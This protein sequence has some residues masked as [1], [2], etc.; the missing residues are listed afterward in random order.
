MFTLGQKVYRAQ[1]HSDKI[2]IGTITEIYWCDLNN[3][4]HIIPKENGEYVCYCASF[5]NGPDYFSKQTYPWR[6]F[7]N[8]RDAYK[9][10]ANQAS[11][12]IR[13]LQRELD[14]WVSIVAEATVKSK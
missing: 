11:R 1:F 2:E 12:H 3:Q 8:E 6:F 7:D 5:V 13:D 14:K 9:Q 10:V 4:G